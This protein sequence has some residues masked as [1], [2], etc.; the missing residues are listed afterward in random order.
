MIGYEDEPGR[1]AKICICEIFGSEADTSG[2]LVGMGIHPFNDSTIRDDFTEVETAIDVSDWHNDTVS[3][4]PAP[5]PSDQ[6]GKSH[7]AKLTCAASPIV[8]GPGQ[9]C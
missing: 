7:E 1:S 2:A 4:R 6:P 3:S 5:H 9:R 8:A